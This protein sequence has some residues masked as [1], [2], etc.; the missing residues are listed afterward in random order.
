MYSGRLRAV[1][2][3]MMLFTLNLEITDRA[4]LGAFNNGDD[5][6]KNLHHPPWDDEKDG[7]RIQ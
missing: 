3:G 6:A 4:V 7:G 5:K 1:A 2:G